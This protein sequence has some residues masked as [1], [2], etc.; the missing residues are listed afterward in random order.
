[1]QAIFSLNK[2]QMGATRGLPSWKFMS[3]IRSARRRNS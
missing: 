2:R 1:M 3:T